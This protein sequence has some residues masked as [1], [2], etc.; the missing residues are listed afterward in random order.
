MDNALE[1]FIET[2]FN[3]ESRELLYR[4][5]GCFSAYNYT[6]P[7]AELV[8]LVSKE[9]NI[10]DNDITDGI[11]ATVEKH[12]SRL[13]RMQR[14][15]VYDDASLSQVLY[16]LEALITLGSI[17]NV[18]DYLPIFSGWEDNVIKLCKTLGLSL[19][20][21]WQDFFYV[22]EDVED[23][24]IDQ[25]KEM[26]KSKHIDMQ[27]EDYE[28]QSKIRKGLI[29]FYK[30]FPALPVLES[31]IRLDFVKGLQY[32]TYLQMFYDTIIDESIPMQELTLILVYFALCSLD[33]HENP[34]EFLRRE[35]NQLF[36]DIT[37]QDRFNANLEEIMEHFVYAGVRDEED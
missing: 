26:F 35:D 36:S 11:R 22:I 8:D 15:K 37:E 27:Q 31:L 4:A 25:L 20:E 28:V 16:V 12:V 10:D 33:G 17:E 19:C 30:I 24:T 9:R 23:A 29:R 3:F 32:D 13:L 21:D 34:F 18:E 5:L 2:K 7:F 14:I 1:V 6:D